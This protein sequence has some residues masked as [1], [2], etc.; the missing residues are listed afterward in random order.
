MTINL[1]ATLKT[2]MCSKEILQTSGDSLPTHLQT[3]AQPCGR[4]YAPH[5]PRRL[6]PSGIWR[7]PLRQGRFQKSG[8]MVG[9]WKKQ[10][11]QSVLYVLIFLI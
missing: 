3:I 1:H 11:R 4:W 5:L 7:F 2:F 10:R 9:G 6:N 8:Q